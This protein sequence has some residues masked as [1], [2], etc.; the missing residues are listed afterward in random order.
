MNA[1]QMKLWSTTQKIRDNAPASETLE[2]SGY[3]FEV[4]SRFVERDCYD[5]EPTPTVTVKVNGKRMAREAA[6]KL[7]S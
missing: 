5:F 6:I 7:L 1:Q 4:T 2:M 3:T